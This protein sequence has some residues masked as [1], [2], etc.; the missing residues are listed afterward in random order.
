MFYL[1]VLLRML[2]RVPPFHVVLYCC[3]V[4]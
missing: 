3:H 1:R 2:S 4:W